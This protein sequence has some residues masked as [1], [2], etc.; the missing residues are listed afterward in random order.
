MGKL[1]SIVFTLILLGLATLS[2]YFIY[3][4][5][6]VS[7]VHV[8]Q[9]KFNPDVIIEKLTSFNYDKQGNLSVKLTTPMMKYNSFTQK[10]VL[11]KPIIIFYQNKQTNNAP[12]VITADTG[13]MT[14]QPKIYKLMGNVVLN[15]GATPT[16]QSTQITTSELTIDPVQ[17]IAQTKQVINFVQTDKNNSKVSVTSKG[18]I[19]NQKTGEVKLLSNAQ[20]V[21]NEK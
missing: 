12:W 7:Q 19:A 8:A 11:T 20:G 10:A 9:N 2:F 5:I 18:A 13:T 14:Q 15:Q 4:T 6:F 1:K 17:N 3:K 16:T 21:Y